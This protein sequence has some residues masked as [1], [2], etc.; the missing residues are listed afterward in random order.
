MELMEKSLSQL[1]KGQQGKHFSFPVVVDI[2]VRIARGMCYL[3]DRGIAH[4]DLK[5]QNVVAN[6]CPGTSDHFCVKL[7]DFGISK[8]LVEFSQ[9]NL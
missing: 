8:I 7:V 2:I 5:P 6:K 4:R 3:H 9:L 1:I